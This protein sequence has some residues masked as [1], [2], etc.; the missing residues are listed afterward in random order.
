MYTA[1]AKATGHDGDLIVRDLVELVATAIDLPGIE[2]I[3]AVDAAGATADLA[4]VS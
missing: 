4:G 1:A 2:E 3:A